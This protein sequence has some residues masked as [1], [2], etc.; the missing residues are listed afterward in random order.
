MTRATTSLGLNLMTEL[1]SGST[2]NLQLRELHQ[3][4]FFQS[5]MHW[6]SERVTALCFIS[7]PLL[8]FIDYLV[9]PESLYPKFAFLRFLA[10]FVL[11]VQYFMIYH[12]QPSKNS[13]AY[14][15]SILFVNLTMTNL[16]IV[17]LGGF[18]SAYSFGIVMI[19]MLLNTVIPWGAL[20]ATLVC[21]ISII[22][23]V[24]TG[25]T[26]SEQYHVDEIVPTLSFFLVAALISVLASSFRLRM[27]Y[28]DSQLKEK[29]S[30]ARA[31]L[32]SEIELAKRIQT[33][34]LPTVHREGAY[35]IS[36]LMV[37]ADEP[38]G[39]Y[40]DIIESRTGESWIAIGD[41]SGSGIESS[42]I[43]MMAQVAI[44]STINK[45]GGS[46]PSSVLSNVNSVLKENIRRLGSERYMTICA[47]K[48]E[49]DELVVAGKHQSILVHRSQKSVT[50]FVSTRGTWLGIVDDIGG[51]LED[52]H[53]EISEGDVVLLFTDGVI[54]ATNTSGEIFKERRLEKELAR[55]S[56][57][58]PSEI[59]VALSSALQEHIHEQK[60]DYTL[61]V[62]K[63][64]TGRSSRL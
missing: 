16:M 11:F 61:V 24:F 38:G 2:G 28:T 49:I 52:I 25:S 56:H 53:I 33:V 63:R 30:E 35:D 44:F 10:S 39:D 42:L 59:V 58:S 17:D 7:L 8:F 22:S 54:E 40:Y 26:S 32:W 47:I 55:I 19:F 13:I 1:A 9:A 57:L 37:P 31:G 21:F 48:V 27:L 51:Y 50:E 15:Y 43:A 5:S 46:S 41:V 36:A 64:K 34:T 4:R 12:S 23:Y 20:H 60:D 6:W 3:S 18:D 14:G 45:S 29:L 62:L